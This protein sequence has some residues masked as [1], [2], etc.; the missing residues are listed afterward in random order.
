MRYQTYRGVGEALTEAACYNIMQLSQDKRE[1][2]IKLL[3]DKQSGAGF[4]LVRVS[5][6]SCDFS[7][8]DV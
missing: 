2:L 3:F 6:G 5:I 1:E 7:I 8:R 4:D